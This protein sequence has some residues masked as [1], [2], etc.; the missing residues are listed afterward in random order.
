[1]TTIKQS[2]SKSENK[3]SY[4]Y[5][6]WMYILKLFDI[7][8][9]FT[10]SFLWIRTYNVKSLK[11]ILFSDCWSNFFAANK[12]SLKKNIV[13]FVSIAV[14]HK[15]WEHTSTLTLPLHVRYSRKFPLH[16]RNSRK[17]PVMYEVAETVMFIYAIA[18]ILLF[19]YE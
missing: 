16:V 14:S 9:S 13:Q 8:L 6:K 19:I 3:Q 11:L 10:C 1:M 17:L 15:R 2:Q 5:K 18:E 4:V 12:P 7:F